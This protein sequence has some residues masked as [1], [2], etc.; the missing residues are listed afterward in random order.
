M[1]C[2]PLRNDLASKAGDRTKHTSN[3]IQ[4]DPTVR[5]VDGSLGSP[6]IGAKVAVKS[7]VCCLFY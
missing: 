7:S 2:L 4:K 1:L 3:I 6:G 5:L